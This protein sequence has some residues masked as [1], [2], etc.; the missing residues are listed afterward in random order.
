MLTTDSPDGE[1]IAEEESQLDRNLAS[2]DRTKHDPGRSSIW[3]ISWYFLSLMIFEGG[4]LP[5]SKI[6]CWLLRLYGAQI[7]QGVVIKPNVRIKYPWKLKVG[8]HS[9]IGQGVWIDNLANVTI[10]RDACLSQGSYLCTGGHDY[11][12]SE[13]DFVDRP[14]AIGDGTWIGAK[15][16]LLPG[17]SIGNRSVVGAGAVVTRSIA[18]GVLAAGN[19]AATIR[20]LY[21]TPRQPR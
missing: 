6:K 3:R 10:G 12:K 14:I 21:A 13:F 1:S 4:L 8:R 16:I 11:R 19:P 7:G 2:Y 5:S 9:W 18:E 15:A 17:V 20:Q